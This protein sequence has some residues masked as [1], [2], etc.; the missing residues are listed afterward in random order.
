MTTN[1]DTPTPAD[2][3]SFQLFSSLQYAP[4]L[5]SSTE[6]TSL[7]G[8]PCPFYLLPYHRDRMLSAAHHFKWS[9]VALEKLRDLKGFQKCCEDGVNE[10]V[11][12]QENKGLDRDLKDAKKAL[13]VLIHAL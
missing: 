9:T 8:S 13:K 5:L 6:N 4:L 2:N 10:F 1:I 12:R 11:S 3:Q 7:C